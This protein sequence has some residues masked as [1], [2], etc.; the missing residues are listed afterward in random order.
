MNTT[1]YAKFDRANNG[2]GVTFRDIPEAITCGFSES[3][4]M[5]MA[6]NALELVL[7]IRAGEGK[8]LP[9]PGPH[10]PGET[11]VTITPLGA[12]KI[13]IILAMREQGITKAALA[14]MLNCHKP[15]IDR[16]VDVDH[17]TKWP[18][19]THALTVL[20]RRLIV[21]VVAAAA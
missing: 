21:D 19:I 6:V 18:M 2:I 20:G 11:Q 14:R 7:A 1:Y 12:A 8:P 17:K 13:A 16:L 9:V 10:E 15:Q 5:E 4:A 3:E